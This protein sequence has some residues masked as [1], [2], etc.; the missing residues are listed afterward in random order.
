MLPQPPVASAQ[1]VRVRLGERAASGSAYR[2]ADAEDDARRAWDAGRT[3]VMLSPAGPL[4][5]HLTAGWLLPGRAIETTSQHHYALASGG[6]RPDA[7]LR[8]QLAAALPLDAAAAQR[9]RRILGNCRRSDRRPRRIGCQLARTSLE[10]PLR[11]PA[12]LGVLGRVAL[13]AQ[14]GVICHGRNAAVFNG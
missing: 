4:A 8:V 2:T 11:R 3:A 13:Y 1:A 12:I 10:S 6:H 14:R 9:A 5:S 7:A